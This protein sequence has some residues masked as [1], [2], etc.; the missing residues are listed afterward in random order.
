[1]IQKHQPAFSYH[2]HKC[3]ARRNVPKASNLSISQWCLR[4]T[5]VF[6]LNDRGGPTSPQARRSEPRSGANKENRHWEIQVLLP[7]EY[8]NKT[9]YLYL[10]KIELLF[11]PLPAS[12]SLLPLKFSLPVRVAYSRRLGSWFS[13]LATLR[14]VH[15]FVARN[16]VRVVGDY[17]DL[18]AMHS[19]C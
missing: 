10:D 13:P 18:N 17:C 14:S 19:S 12:C 6:G 9:G 15:R 7:Y 1:M 2:Q 8:E 11:P 16:H 4:P 5:I 3:R